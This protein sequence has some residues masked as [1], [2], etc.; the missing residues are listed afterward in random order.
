MYYLKNTK[1]SVFTSESMKFDDSGDVDGYYDILNWQWLRND[2]LSF[3]KI[4]HYTS[5]GGGAGFELKIDNSSI[6]WNTHNGLVG[7][8]C[9]LLIITFS[10]HGEEIMEYL[11]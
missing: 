8:K 10:N 3:T 7:T 4:G 11:M 6:F 5:K 9:I 1:F 2:S